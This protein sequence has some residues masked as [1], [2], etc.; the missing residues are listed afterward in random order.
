MEPL[1]FTFLRYRLISRSKPNNTYHTSHVYK[2]RT[3]LASTTSQR[4][5]NA[6]HSEL[7]LKHELL[8]K[9]RSKHGTSTTITPPAPTAS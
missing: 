7:K 6:E 2:H 8:P 4:K 1:T 5:G 9:H 3:T